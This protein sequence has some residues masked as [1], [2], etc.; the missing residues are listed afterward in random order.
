MTITSKPT[1]PS[2]QN[3]FT[4][5][6]SCGGTCSF[7]CSVAQMGSRPAFTQCNSN[8]YTASSLQ[9]GLVYVFQVRGTDDVGNQGSSVNYTWKV[10]KKPVQFLIIFC[11]PVKVLS[12]KS[13]VH[14]VHCFCLLFFKF[15]IGDEIPFWWQNCRFMAWKYGSEGRGVVKAFTCCRDDPVWYPRKWQQTC[16]C[17]WFSVLLRE[18]FF[19]NTGVHQ[20]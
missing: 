10:G 16:V 12:I 15:N 13:L 9:N 4:F 17:C 14:F 1:S 5:Q 20:K 2:N 19:G 3:S 11:N 7:Q 6:F 18:V 8:R